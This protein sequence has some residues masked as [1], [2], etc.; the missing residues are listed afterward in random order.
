MC[1]RHAARPTTATRRVRLSRRVGEQVAVAL[2]RRSSTEAGEPVQPA[3]CCKALAPTSPTQCNPSTHCLQ[4]AVAG[5]IGPLQPD[6]LAL[7]ERAVQYYGRQPQ[8]W[9]IICRDH[10]PHRQPKVWGR[11]G[12]ASRQGVRRWPPIG[13]CWL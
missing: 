13:C 1:C 10:L 9:E 7:L 11:A 3:C 5:I 2:E 6:E 8:R 12:A 4:D